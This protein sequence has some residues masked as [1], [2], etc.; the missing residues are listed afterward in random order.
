MEEENSEDFINALPEEL[1]E[2]AREDLKNLEE[3][4]EKIIKDLTEDNSEIKNSVGRPKGIPAS[5]AQ[6]ASVSKAATEYQQ[7]LK[8]GLIEKT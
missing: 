5:E 8:D 4:N 1:Q 2:E 6:K 7:K 3:E